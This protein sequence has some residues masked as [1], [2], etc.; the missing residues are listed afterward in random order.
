MG[1]SQSTEPTDDAEDHA[2]FL[3]DL[4]WLLLSSSQ[5]TSS[6]TLRADREKH[7]LFHWIRLTLHMLIWMCYKRIDDYWNVDLSKHW[8]DSWR[9][10]TFVYVVGTETDKDSSDNKLCP[11]VW[12]KNGKAAQNRK[13]QEWAKRKTETRQRNPRKF[14]Q[15]IGRPVAP[16]MLCERQT[17]IA[18]VNVWGLMNPQD[19]ERNLC[20]PKST[21]IA[22]QFGAQIYSD[23]TSDENSG[24]KSFRG[25]GMEKKLEIPAWNLKKEQ[26]GGY[27]GSTKRQKKSKFPYRW[28]YVNSKTRS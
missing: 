14:E 11:E 21:K 7:S 22:L 9:G 28:T 12:A 3:V 2:D 16:T 4:R 1:E 27:S 10:L 19:K 6:S 25:Q 8:S 26:K 15:K 20:N 17:S 24:C 13:K 5:W 23:A 18:K